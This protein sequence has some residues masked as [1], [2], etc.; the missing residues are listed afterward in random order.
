MISSGA[1]AAIPLGH[2]DADSAQ[3]FQRKHAK[4][5]SGLG[6]HPVELDAHMP[7]DEHLQWHFRL[8]FRFR[9]RG[10]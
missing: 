8:E 3:R 2:G 7:G 1:F 9:C 4:R 5:L 10:W 6:V